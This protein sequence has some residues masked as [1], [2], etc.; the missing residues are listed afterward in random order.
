MT[1]DMIAPYWMHQQI[2]AGRYDSWTDEQ[3]AGIEIVDGMV[4]VAPS[5]S[6]RHNRIATT[7][8]VALEAAAGVPDVPGDRCQRGSCSRRRAVRR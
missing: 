2:S 3:C 1:A 6:K 7:L 8:A 5:A 4:V